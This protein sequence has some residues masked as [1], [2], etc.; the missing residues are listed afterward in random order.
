MRV[1]PVFLHEMQPFF[2]IHTH[3]TAAA[4]ALWNGIWRGEAEAATWT[5]SRLSVGI[6]PWYIEDD[7]QAQCA[8]YTQWV[9]QHVHRLEALGEAGLDSVRG[10]PMAVQQ[11]VFEAHIQLS[12]ALRLPLILHCVRAHEPLLAL[13]K[14]HKPRQAWVFHGFSMR[15]TVAKQLTDAGIYLSFGAAIL[16]P[17]ASAGESLAAVPASQFFLETDDSDVQ[18][19]EI[20]A[21]AAAIRGIS[22]EELAQQ[23]A[24]NYDFIQ[25]DR[26]R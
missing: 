18:I 19:A 20:Y 17:A 10:A 13:R 6:H 25:Q 5:Q 3:R 7:W 1:E 24:A 26:S 8:H 21:A 16:R 15:P 4:F 11:A 23:I 22:A 9:Q 14:Q 12:E 2:D